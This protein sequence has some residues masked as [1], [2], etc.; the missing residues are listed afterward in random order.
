MN[1]SP[2][3]ALASRVWETSWQAGLLA[4]LILAVRAVLG[5][6]L[7]AW[8]R[9]ALWLLVLARLILPALPESRVSIYNWT[10][11]VP[12]A[13]GTPSVP[14]TAVQQPPAEESLSVTSPSPAPV[15]S[16]ARL[17]VPWLS[18]AWLGGFLFC[19]ALGLRAYARFW[20]MVR[21]TRR[22]PSSEILSLF[23]EARRTSGL[24]RARLLVAES[25]SSPA[26]AGLFRPAI[27]LPADLE[28]QLDGEQLRLVLLHELAHVRRGDVWTTWACW[29]LGAVHWFNP[30]LW[31]AFRKAAEDRELACDESVLARTQSAGPYGSALLRVWEA[32]ARHHATLGIVGIFDGSSEIVRRMHRILAYRRPTLWRSLLGTSVLV[33]LALCTLTGQTGVPPAPQETGTPPSAAQQNPAQPPP[34]AGI[35]TSNIETEFIMISI[36]NSAVDKVLTQESRNMY[37]AARQL[38]ETGEAQL[39]DVTKLSAQNGTHVY[40]V[41]LFRTDVEPVLSPNGKSVNVNASIE[42]KEA[43][44]TF[45]ADLPLDRQTCAGSFAD[46]EMDATAFVFVRAKLIEL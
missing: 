31:L 10:P 17:Q 26:V 39:R 35:L 14:A 5:H 4:L 3:E 36:A 19:A 43:K 37:A 18:L 22:Q 1:F 9:H 11:E 42:R 28:R 21:R 6:R 30:V 23:E 2:L 32:R 29:F 41:T 16:A 38:L 27:L 13:S 12:A 7:P 40:A 44:L 15:I 20:R 34:A 46:P 8:C 45:S 24:A 33:L 25:I